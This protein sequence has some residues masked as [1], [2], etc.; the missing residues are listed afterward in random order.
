MFGGLLH[1]VPGS[2]PPGDQAP[3]QPL[4]VSWAPTLTAVHII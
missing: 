2:H 4:Q 1:P 3:A